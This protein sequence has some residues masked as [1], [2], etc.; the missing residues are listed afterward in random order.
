[1]GTY[2]T[3]PT[4]APTGAIILQPG[5]NVSAIVNAAPTGATF[6][7][8]PGVYHG[9][10]LAPKSGQTFLGAEGAILNGSDTLTNFTHQGNAWVIGGQMQ[11]GQRVATDEGVSGAMRAG[12]PE[13]VFFDNT[14]LKPVDALSKLTSGTFYFDYTNHQIYLADDPTGHVVEAGKLADAFHGSA[15]NVT[16]QN[17]VIEKYDSPAQ[18]GAIMGGQNWTVKDSEVRLNY[19][20]G[21]KLQDN[22]KIV[23]NSV[24]DNGQMGLGGSGANILVDSNEI[25]HNGYWSG[26]DVLWEGGGFKFTRTDGLVVTNNFSHDNNGYGMWTDIN[27]IHTLYANNLIEH[28][29]AAG[30]SHEI[31]Y[32]ATIRDNVLIDN[33]AQD[34]RSWWWGN[35]IQIQNSSNVDIYGNK[36]D[37]TGGS[38]G[39]VLIQQNRGTGTY[40]PWLTTG[41]T[42][43]DNIIV[44]HGGAGRDGFIGGVTDYQQST[45]L[46]NNTWS[47]NQ[48][49][50]ADSSGKFSWGSDYNFA[51]FES[52]SSGSGSSISQNYPDESSWLAG[53]PGSGDAGGTTTGT[54]DTGGATGTGTGAADGNGT[55]TST[56]DTGTGSG[57]GTSTGGTGTGAGDGNGTGTNTGDTGTGSGTGTS[58]GAGDGNG[59]GTSTG[60]TGTGSGTGTSAGGTGTGAGDGNGTGTSTGDTGTGS[61]TGTSTGGTGTGAGDGNG[62][63]TNTGNTGTGSGTGTSTG[64]G[65]GNGTGTSTGDTGT[66]SGTGTSAGGTGTGAGDGNG[67]GT[68]TGERVQGRYWRHRHGRR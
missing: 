11:Q 24:H 67:T 3:K 21:I 58:T 33:G 23:G 2:G 66:G 63:G 18:S 57:T 13:T 50:M 41:N 38:N 31:S 45:M 60:D 48:Y 8:E 62:T 43:H 29:T 10:S 4:S 39:I 51:G 28:N 30:I 12:Y 1:M 22:S 52:H 15:Q 47:N 54:G 14:P 19:G 40:G 65:D 55:G 56:G 16:I 32:D 6:Y 49:Y 53:M 20:V 26:I 68:S 64:A 9:V 37:M 36:I 59:T 44:D 17:L 61:G 27:N 42:V 34:P 35:E 46:N 25:A 5:D 7:F